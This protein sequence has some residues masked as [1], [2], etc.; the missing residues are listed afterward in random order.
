MF[1]LRLALIG[2]AAVDA[3]S[4]LRS[5]PMGMHRLHIPPRSGILESRPGG[6]SI[7]AS[8]AVFPTAIYWTTVQIGSPPQDFAVGLDS[9]SGDLFVEG[10]GCS[11][12][13]ATPPN[14]GYDHASSS[15]SKSAFPFYFTHSYGTC[16]IK[17]P[18][19][20]C[21]LRGRLFKDQVSLAGL[22]P[23]EIEFG[24][25]Q[26]Q[27]SNFDTK[28][29]IGGLMG[30]A[31]E[32]GKDVFATLVAAGK[33]ANVWGLCMYEGRVS[34]GTLSI[35]G[36]DAR[37]A[38]GEIAYVPDSGFAF[39]SV[40]VESIALAGTQLGIKQAAILDTGTNVL[41]L[42]QALY[43]QVQHAM[44]SDPSLSHCAALYDTKCFALTDVEVDK[45]PSLTF[46]LVGTALEMT[47]RDYLLRGSPLADAAGQYCL[48][49]RSGGDFIIGET[50]MRNYYIVFD[51]EQKRIGWG[52][53]NKDTCGSISG[54]GYSEYVVA[55]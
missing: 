15:T 5:V 1:A 29:V 34:N 6:H 43:L 7:P 52:R 27:T 3:S 47:S 38:D 31:G 37:L 19:A 23:V 45:Y 22:G 50:T 11:G 49:I 10:K 35:G 9:G 46:R 44:C 16:N 12:C 26:S 51:Y 41:V 36:V 33:C 53:V 55:V 21:T 54:A 25:I 18:S 48:G 4:Q 2:A 24:A 13:T 17:D 32:G 40:D 8:G 14:R 42:P 20:T 28:K 39:H 30:L